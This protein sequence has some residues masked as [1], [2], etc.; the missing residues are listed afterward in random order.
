MLGVKGTECIGSRKSNYHT[1][2]T[3]MAPCYYW[4]LQLL[5]YV[6]IIQPKARQTCV[7]LVDF[8]YPVYTL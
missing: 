5:H 3:T 2:T 4:N 8:D 6:L 7:I 1:I